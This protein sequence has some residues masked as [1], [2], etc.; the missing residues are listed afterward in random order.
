MQK[1]KDFKFHTEL[2]KLTLPNGEV[3]YWSK[4]FDIDRE[5]WDILYRRRL[6]NYVCGMS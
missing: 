5:I 2:E 4:W 6:E 3:V 1:L